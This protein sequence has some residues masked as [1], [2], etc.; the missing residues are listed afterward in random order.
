MS[1]EIVI[2]I[3]EPT[4]LLNKWQRMHWRKRRDLTERFSW[5]V[6]QALGYAP[7]YP[8]QYCVV[9]VERHSAGLPDWDGLYGGLKP[10]L[11]CL[12]RR[13]KVNPHGLG[14]IEDDSPK[15]IRSLQAT[16]CK[17]KRGEAKTIIRIIDLGEAK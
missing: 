7:R 10:A 14:I 4:P 5:L 15:V 3:P 8:I 13:T 6:R 1:T 16:P 9:V 17:S 11:D 12:V 2:E